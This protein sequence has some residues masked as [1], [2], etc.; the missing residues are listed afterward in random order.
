VV[1]IM[2]KCRKKIR[3]FKKSIKLNKCINTVIMKTMTKRNRSIKNT[4]KDKMKSWKT[5]QRKK[6]DSLRNL[7]NY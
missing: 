1:L 2:R 7:E 4:E 6:R 3:N 5:R